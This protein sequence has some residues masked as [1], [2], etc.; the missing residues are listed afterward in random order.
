MTEP[1]VVASR[2]S[3]L[4]LWQ[5][6][7]VVERLSRV[8][9]D[10]SF[11]THIVNTTGD[12]ILDVPLSDI[13]DKGLFTR[14]ID[15][16]LIGGQAAF[17][18]HSLKDLPTAIP[19]ELVIAAITERWDVRD[20]FISNTYDSVEALPQGAVVATG[21]L[22]RRAQLLSWR[23][24][25]S[26]IDIR[27]NVNTRLRKLD[28]SDWDGMMLAV[29]GLERLEMTERIQERIATER[30]LP[31]VGQGSFAVVCR[32]DDVDTRKL[33]AAIHDGPSATAALAE[34]AMLRRLEGGCQVPIGAMGTVDGN[35][36]T[37][38]G[39][40]GAL[41]GSRLIRRAMTGRADDP[42]ALG[43]RMA[44]ALLRDGGNVIL[45][46]IREAGATH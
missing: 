33:L 19:E 27:G 21:S 3:D 37:L 43:I 1:I 35:T 16:I 26:I 17:A 44:E 2:G 22:R 34:R 23:P 46:S 18:V 31:A 9:P 25:L 7:W 28:E 42:E 29:A 8:R 30:I 45:D 32:K 36:L 6:R 4:A 11:D 15:A 39:C 24:D 12:Q 38:D 5:T 40:I 10:L 20:A 14:E 13:G 41:D